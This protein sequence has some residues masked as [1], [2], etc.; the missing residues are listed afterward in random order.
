MIFEET[1]KRLNQIKKIRTKDIDLIAK[2]YLID[3]ADITDLYPHIREN[4]AI[5]RIYF[6]VSLKRIN[7]YNQQLLFIERHFEY[8]QDWWHVDILTQLLL[9]DPGFE[10]VYRKAK[11]YVLSDMLFVRRWGYVIFLTGFQKE[12]E[13]TKAIIQLMHDD[14]EYYVQMAEAWLLADLAIYNPNEV[15]DYIKLKNLNYNIIGK[16][17]QKICDSFRISED[18]KKRVKE[19]RALYKKSV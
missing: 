10:Y 6:V 12:P 2:D 11:E 14:N 19:L 16:A 4:S 15:F 7:N 8:L 3:N 1:I 13:H 9:K 5:H 17:I 18:Y